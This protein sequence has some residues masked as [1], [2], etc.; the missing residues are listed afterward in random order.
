MK[1]RIAANPMRRIEVD[2][3][4]I[5]MS[6]G[7][8]GEKLAKVEKLLERIASQKPIK[9]QAKRT[10]QPFGIKK[11]EAIACKVS[12]RR[13][14]ANNFLNRCFKIQDKLLMS[15]FDTYGNFKQEWS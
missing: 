6:V 3:V 5:N 12:L 9:R 1:E 15:Q 7:E 10:M 2:K 11:G 8:G 14:R 13:E 4:V